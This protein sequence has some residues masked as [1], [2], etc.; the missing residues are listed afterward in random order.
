MELLTARRAALLG[1]VVALAWSFG[2][3][4]GSFIQYLLTRLVV[5][6]LLNS[7]LG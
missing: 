1:F 6:P 7:L 5:N 2:A 3:Y 4:L